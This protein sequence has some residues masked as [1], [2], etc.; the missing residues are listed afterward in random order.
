M[1]VML[2]SECEWFREPENGEA[3]KTAFG[4]NFASTQPTDLV[5][6]LSF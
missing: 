6:P 1:N 3:P 5:E 4:R 2:V